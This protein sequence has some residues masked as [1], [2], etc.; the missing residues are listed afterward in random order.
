MKN[1]KLEC[2]MAMAMARKDLLNKRDPV[3][4][5]Y[6]VKKLERKIRRL[7]GSVNVTEIE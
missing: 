5:K 6:I 4:N 7:G 1:V 2:E 3:A